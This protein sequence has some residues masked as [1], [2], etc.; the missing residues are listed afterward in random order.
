[1]GGVLRGADQWDDRAL[2]SGLGDK[3]PLLKN[4][5]IR[6]KSIGELLLVII[7]GP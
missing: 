5:M 2:W 4:A 1:M 3:E 6:R 7:I